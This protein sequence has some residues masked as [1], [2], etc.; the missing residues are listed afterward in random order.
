MT[1]TSHWAWLAPS[2]GVGI[3]CGRCLCRLRSTPCWFCKF[4]ELLHDAE[5][6]LLGFDPIS[7]LKP[8][9]GERFLNL[10]EQMQKVI[11]A[12]YGLSWWTKEEKAKHKKSDILA[13][14]CEAVHVA[15]W[16][17]EEVRT[18]LNIQVAPL[19]DDPL[20]AVYGGVPWEPWTTDVANTRFLQE[21]QNILK[22]R[23]V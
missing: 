23:Q 11:F 13:A 21:L 16:S 3:P 4:G 17:Q 19:V 9:L 15:G 8:F 2:A 1:R 7:P 14:A 12:K 18:V 20:V 10:M 6:G 22:S 5:E